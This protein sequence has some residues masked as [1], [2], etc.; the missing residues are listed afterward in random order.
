MGDDNCRNYLIYGKIT[1][2]ANYNT[3]FTRV[4]S[5]KPCSN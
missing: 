3:R 1:I 5:F 4:P 2:V